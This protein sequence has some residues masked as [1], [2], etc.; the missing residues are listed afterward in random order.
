M[1]KLIW[2]ERALTD[3]EDIYDYIAKDSPTYAQY[4]TE[5]IVTAVE[6]LCQFPKSGRHLPEF[7]Y[8]PHRELIVGRHRVIYRYDARRDAIHLV[9]VIHGS[10]LLQPTDV[11]GVRG[12]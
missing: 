3:V 9:T 11:G 1:A 5:R 2:S 8:L 10:R 4:Q 6:R 12:G 7:P